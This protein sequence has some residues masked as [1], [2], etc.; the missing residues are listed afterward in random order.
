MPVSLVSPPNQGPSNAAAPATSPPPPAP[1]VSSL[2]KE[3]KRKHLLTSNTDPLLPELRD[4]NFSVVG[5]R[6]NRVAHRLDEDYKARFQAKTVPQLRDFVGKLGGL[7]TEHQSLRLREYACMH[8]LTVLDA[9]LLLVQI[10]VSRKCSYRLH[11][12]SYSTNP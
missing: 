8:L 11:G 9:D 7:Q 4:L 2:N 12:Q 1:P 5:K 3:K 6:L 10:L